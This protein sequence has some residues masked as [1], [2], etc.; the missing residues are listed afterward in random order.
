MMC[1]HFTHFHFFQL[2]LST[3][4]SLRKEGFRPGDTLSLQL[5][6]NGLE[7]DVSSSARARETDTELDTQQETEQEACRET[8]RETCHG[9]GNFV[10]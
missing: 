9:T 6:S 8:C 2:D 5:P 10:R 3:S 4:Q 1:D 7:P